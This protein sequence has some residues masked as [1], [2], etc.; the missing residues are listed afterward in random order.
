MNK[1]TQ[2]TSPFGPTR[3]PIICCTLRGAGATAC[4]SAL[5]SRDHTALP[6]AYQAKKTGPCNA[7]VWPFGAGRKPLGSRPFFHSCCSGFPAVR[8]LPLP[9]SFRTP[10]SAPARLWR[11]PRS[12]RTALIVAHSTFYAPH[13]SPM[14]GVTRFPVP[15]SPLL[16]VIHSGVCQKGHVK[17]HQIRVKIDQKDDVFRQKGIKK[18][19]ISSC[20]S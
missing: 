10:H 7:S 13:F 2:E 4:F 16:R 6:D 14:M 15:R 5:I 9:L 12:L 3:H 1:K 19:R 20:P 8:R 11:V 18:A 17:N